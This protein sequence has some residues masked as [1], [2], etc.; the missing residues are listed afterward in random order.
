MVFEAFPLF[1]HMV[2]MTDPLFLTIFGYNWVYYQQDVRD[3]GRLSL[4][5]NEKDVETLESVFLIGC[6][7]GLPSG[8]G[9]PWPQ[10]WVG[11]EVWVS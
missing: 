9:S 1:S 7:S 3:P 10:G 6:G 2:K 8:V 5:Y 11:G 4:E